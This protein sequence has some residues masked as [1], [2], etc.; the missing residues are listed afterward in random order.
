MF[1]FTE[2]VHAISWSMLD[3]ILDSAGNHLKNCNGLPLCTTNT[4]VMQGTIDQI[5]II[6]KYIRRF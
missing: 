4:F 2:G 5:T 1:Y 3:I 6:T